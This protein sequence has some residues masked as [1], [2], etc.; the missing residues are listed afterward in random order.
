MYEFNKNTIIHNR[1]NICSWLRTNKIY[2]KYITPQVNQGYNGDPQ[3]P[4]NSPPSFKKVHS[5]QL[6]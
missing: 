5:G 6:I 4:Q 3:Q 1:K 2:I